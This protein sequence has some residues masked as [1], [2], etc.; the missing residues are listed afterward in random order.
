MPIISIQV[1]QQWDTN[2]NAHYFH[3]SVA[4]VGTLCPLF[5]YKCGI[6]GIQTLCPLFSYNDASVAVVTY[7]PYAHYFHT[8][9]Q[10]WRWWHTNPMPII[11]IQVWQRWDAN[12][13]CSLFSYKC[14]SGG[15]QTLGAHYFQ[16][17]QVGYKPYDHYFNT[18]GSCGIQ[19]L[20]PL[21]SCSVVVVGYKSYAHYFHAWQ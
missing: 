13:R 10:V 7:K 11:F 19:T 20:C 14:G 5:S 2:L 1:W 8:M 16:V 6:G 4:S 18:Y 3:T 15:M 21:F 17:G 12:P 9:I